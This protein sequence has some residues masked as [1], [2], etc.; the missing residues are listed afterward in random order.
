MIIFGICLISV[1]IVFLMLA[2]IF[3]LLYRTFEHQNNKTAKTGAFLKDVKHKKDVPLVGR[4]W[5]IVSV[6]KDQSKGIYKYT[7]NN[8][9][10]KIRYVEFVTLRQMPQIVQVIYLKKF[11]RIA[12]VK[13]DTSLPPFMVHTLVSAV[14]AVQFIVFGCLLIFGLV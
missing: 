1:G 13:T 6:I 9:S 3:F 10:Y 14:F 12:Y 5:R 4:R 2:G 7:V 11:P 8:K